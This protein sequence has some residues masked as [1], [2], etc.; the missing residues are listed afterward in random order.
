MTARIAVPSL[1][2]CSGVLQNRLRF[3]IVQPASYYIIAPDIMPAIYV[4]SHSE[5][6]SDSWTFQ[7][8]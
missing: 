5:M 7:N 3:S 6:V 1:S 8:T 2:A 4:G